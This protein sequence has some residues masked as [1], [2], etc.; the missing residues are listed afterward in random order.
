MIDQDNA[1]VG[2]CGDWE[3]LPLAFGLPDGEDGVIARWSR[4]NGTKTTLLTI[5]DVRDTSGRDLTVFF[6]SA[7]P[8]GLPREAK[9]DPLSG[10]YRA[11]SWSL[12]QFLLDH[13]FTVLPRA[14]A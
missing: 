11:P 14:R 4:R 13:G 12:L 1:Y 9:S 6:Y 10:V 8:V 2:P 5:Y 3:R 7:S